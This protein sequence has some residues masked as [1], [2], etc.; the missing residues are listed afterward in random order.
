V[1]LDLRSDSAFVM[2]KRKL[3]IILYCLP[4]FFSSLFSD[5]AGSNLLLHYVQERRVST[6][7]IGNMSSLIGTISFAFSF[8]LANIVDRVGYRG[9]V[10]FSAP[11]MGLSTYVLYHC[12]FEDSST[13][14]I[15]WYALFSTLK[16]ILPVNM[17]FDIIQFKIS[18]VD[19]RTEL[20]GMKSW[21]S[22]I[23]VLS[24]NVLLIVVGKYSLMPIYTKYLFPSFIAFW[25]IG[26]LAC[27]VFFH[28][29][30]SMFNRNKIE[31]S[32]K[33]KNGFKQDLFSLFEF[34]WNHNSEFRKYL[35]YISFDHA[36]ALCFSNLYAL[37]LVHVISL[38]STESFNYYR[39]VL[40]VISMVVSIVA[41]PLWIKIRSS[42]GSRR[43]C[44]LNY[45]LQIFM[46]A[47]VFFIFFF[48]ATSRVY[49]YI[50]VVLIKTCV[51]C[52]FGMFMDDMKAFI[53]DYDQYLSGERRVA[54]ISS[55]WGIASSFISLPGS[56][57]SFFLLE[58]V[59]SFD[60]SRE[61]LQESRTVTYINIMATLLPCVSALVNLYIFYCM[62]NQDE[63]VK[64]LE[65]ILRSEEDAKN[66]ARDPLHGGKKPI[67]ERL[68]K[69]SKK[70]FVTIKDGVMFAIIS[71][72]LFA[73][74]VYTSFFKKGEVYRIASLLLFFFSSMFVSF[75]MRAFQ[76]TTER[77]KVK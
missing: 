47:F 50:S 48:P 70:R 46:G 42:L 58:N 67:I 68:S 44:L 72:C 16:N 65:R 40:N 59:G 29:N 12:P 8:F 31:T 3:L 39:S 43:A 22:S 10:L 32:K 21:I 36:R 13:G 75:A 49:I 64:K 51:D 30:E 54:S 61:N 66:E 45:S 73:G 71:G 53:F 33:K 15:I 26:M 37:Y 14:L 77:I 1:D 25:C 52:P 6:A 11:L 57:V 56:S 7:L 19:L 55:L 69:V 63:N 74:G 20:I 60:S 24:S 35:Y 41:N 23:S 18:D 2:N 34:S 62:K 38:A 4:V 28:S 9:V 17:A 76:T 27:V 5:F